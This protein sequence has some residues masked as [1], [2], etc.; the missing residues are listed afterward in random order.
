MPAR[1]NTEERRGRFPSARHCSPPRR[2]THLLYL[3]SH[4]DRGCTSVIAR[5]NLRTALGVHARS[6]ADDDEQLLGAAVCASAV[7]LACA[8]GFVRRGTHCTAF[9]RRRADVSSQRFLCAT[10]ALRLGVRRDHLHQ[11]AQHPC[12]TTFP[13]QTA[14][15]LTNHAVV[16]V[17][18]PVAPFRRAEGVSEGLRAS[19]G[20][21]VARSSD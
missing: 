5:A 12:T 1:T 8:V 17:Y 7:D 4:Q 19:Q 6:E 2:G 3:R 16:L 20:A 14:L 13:N 10:A 9:D 18:P 15:S 11:P 21:T